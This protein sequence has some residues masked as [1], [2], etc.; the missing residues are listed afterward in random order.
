MKRESSDYTRLF[1]ATPRASKMRQKPKSA[2]EHTASQVFL[3]H[4]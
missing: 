1:F 4:P 3:F 2:C